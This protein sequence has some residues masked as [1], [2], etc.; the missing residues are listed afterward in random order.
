MK[1]I[2]VQVAET[3]EERASGKC[4]LDATTVVV[5]SPVTWLPGGPIEDAIYRGQV[6]IFT[7]NPILA[8]VAED[9]LRRHGEENGQHMGVSTL[10]RGA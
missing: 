7:N 3:D 9:A 1:T 6:L 5:S 10:N 8:K 2:E 4:Y